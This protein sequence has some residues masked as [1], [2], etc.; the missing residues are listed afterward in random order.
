MKRKVYWVDVSETKESL[1][2]KSTICD[3]ARDK[4]ACVKTWRRLGYYTKVGIL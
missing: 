2:F 1:P 3:G 4:D